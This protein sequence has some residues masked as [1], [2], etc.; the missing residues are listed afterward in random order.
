MTQRLAHLYHSL[1]GILL[2]LSVVLLAPVRRIRIGRILVTRIGHLSLN[3]ELY[4]LEQELASRIRGDKTI[5]LFFYTDSPCNN[6]LL[7]MW[8][9]H[10]RIFKSPILHSAFI[11][12]QVIPFGKYHIIPNNLSSDRDLLSLIPTTSCKIKI[13]QSKAQLCKEQL[14]SYGVLP[15]D[16]VALF[17]I[18]DS[19]YLQK[20]YPGTDWSYHSWRDVAIENYYPSMLYLAE[21]GYKVF[22]MGSV[23]AAR[24]PALHPNVI[25]Y[26]FSTLRSEL[27]DIY[28]ASICDFC[29]S[30]GTG[31]EALPYIFRKNLLLTNIA[32]LGS[33][34]TSSPAILAIPR[35]YYD[36]KLR[37]PLSHSA[38]VQSSKDYIL[39]TNGFLANDILLVDN[40]KEE[41][42]EAVKEITEITS[43]QLVTYSQED[44]RRQQI[45][46]KIFNSN[47]R[48]PIS[49]K[50]LHGQISSRIGSKFLEKNSHWIN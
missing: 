11:A 36:L 8:Q 41:I 20:T 38:I 34:Y 46:W 30:S 5:D 35:H 2:A 15:S 48:S 4:R 47:A 9:E 23:A 14:C 27:Q 12:L 45:F 19:E 25:D 13:N 31:Y 22:R 3:T 44:Q 21:Q 17:I 37:T 18:R 33:I 24:I 43:G 29:V 40:T 39:D 1:V 32:P 50:P 49:G 10:L 16:K 6:E 7:L 28:L 26:P 42:L